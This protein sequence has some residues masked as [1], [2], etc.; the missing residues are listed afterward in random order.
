MAQTPEPRLLRPGRPVPPGQGRQ[1]RVVLRDALAIVVQ[2][3]A[4]GVWR[5]SPPGSAGGQSCQADSAFPAA[6]S[7][8]RQRQ[9][10][11]ATL[12]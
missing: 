3:P 1:D 11:P 2:P 4:T 12:R 9:S 10:R 5:R 8:S 6:D 7:P